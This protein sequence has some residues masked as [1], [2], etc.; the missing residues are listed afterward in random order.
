[1]TLAI[2]RRRLIKAGALGLAALSTPAFA[3]ILTARGFTHGIASGQPAARSVLLWTRYV[4]SGE[5]QLH[6]EVS[7]DECFSRIAAVDVVFASPVHH[8]F[9][10]LTFSCLPPAHF[11]FFLFLSP[12]PPLLSFFLTLPLPFF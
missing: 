10:H 6:C 5:T 2:D 12:S 3:Q 9:P 11:S 4:G 8:I 7:L 1:M